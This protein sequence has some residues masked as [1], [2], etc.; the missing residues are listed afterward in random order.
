MTYFNNA[1]NA[2]LRSGPSGSGGIYAH[3]PS[4]SQT[5]AT[6]T[7][8]QGE[9]TATDSKHADDEFERRNEECRQYE[10]P[11][12]YYQLEGL[13]QKVWRRPKLLLKGKHGQS[14][15]TRTMLRLPKFSSVLHDLE[16][17]P[18]RPKSSNGPPA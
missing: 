11:S 6:D 5:L 2:N 8:E 14:L 17:L 12:R 4:L 3:G 15:N 18:R 10:E 13:N 1:N 7:E 16:R 9:W